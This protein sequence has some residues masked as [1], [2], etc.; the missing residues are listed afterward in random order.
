MQFLWGEL[1]STKWCANECPLIVVYSARSW[2]NTSYNAHTYAMIQTK[3]ATQG[4]VLHTSV[5][6]SYSILPYV[7][8]L[9]NVIVLNATK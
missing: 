1:L 5:M 9:Q 8:E 4:V 6:V 3:E 7:L 2:H